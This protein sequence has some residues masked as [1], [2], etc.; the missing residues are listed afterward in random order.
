[1]SILMFDPA[2]NVA[3][4]PEPVEDVI[5]EL[6]RQ[7]EETDAKIAQLKGEIADTQ[8]QLDWPLL[9]TRDK[10]DLSIEKGVRSIGRDGPGCGRGF[11]DY[12]RA[13]L[14]SEGFDSFLSPADISAAYRLAGVGN[15]RSAL[16]Q[17]RD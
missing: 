6:E 1:M 11:F 2:R 3:P 15:H 5:Q 9:S 13:A 10:R 7:I 16:D 12:V 8:R 14:L 4:S 17:K